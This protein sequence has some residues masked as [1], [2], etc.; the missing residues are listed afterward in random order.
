MADGDLICGNVVAGIKKISTN[1]YTI[2]SWTVPENTTARLEAHC[3]AQQTDDPDVKGSFSIIATVRRSGSANPT[4]SSG[5][6]EVRTDESAATMSL[7]MS[8]NGTDI[9]VE[10]ISADGNEYLMTCFLEMY[11]VVQTLAEA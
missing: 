4:I 8:V 3:V 7:T 1:S 6:T 5:P 9:A 11:S 2:C 10:T